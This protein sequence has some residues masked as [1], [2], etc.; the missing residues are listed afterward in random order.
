MGWDGMGVGGWVW[1]D[2]S[3]ENGGHGRMGVG[4]VV[5]EEHLLPIQKRK[6]KRKKRYAEI[7]SNTK[8]K[9]PLRALNGLSML[10]EW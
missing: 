10:E 5:L 9:K 8:E 1:E 4:A 3:W 6:E 2:G 7:T